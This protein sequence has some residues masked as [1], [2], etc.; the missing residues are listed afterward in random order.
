MLTNRLEK[1]RPSWISRYSDYMPLWA[2]ESEGSATGGRRRLRA[3]TVILASVM[4]II[5]IPLVFLNMGGI[6][7]SRVYPHRGISYSGS[8]TKPHGMRIV[9]LVFY[10]RR[11]NVQVLER[12]L[13]VRHNVIGANGG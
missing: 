10:G 9:A 5:L 2:K 3:C 8:W 12:Y 1:F 6:A 4:I 13:R 7:T 11:A